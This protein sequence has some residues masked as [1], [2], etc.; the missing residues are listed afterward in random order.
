M[1]INYIS[2]VNNIR[3]AQLY[4]LQELLRLEHNLKG[5]QYTSGQINKTD[6]EKYLNQEFNPKEELI[7]AEILKYR[8]ILKNDI[9][10]NTDLKDVII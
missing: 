8:A 9:T 6:W 1:P 7:T 10:L 5:K 3:Y 2:N 4:R